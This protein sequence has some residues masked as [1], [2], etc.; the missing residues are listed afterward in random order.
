[1]FDYEC[2]DCCYMDI[3]PTK[4]G[5]FKCDNR[6]SGYDFVYADKDKC[7]YFAECFTWNRPSSDRR[8]LREISRNKRRYIMTAM[9]EI[10]GLPEENPYSV[11]CGEMIY[12]Y[13]I[14]NQD[15]YDEFITKYDTYGPVLADLLRRDP[16]RKNVCE[17]ILYLLGDYVCLVN[18]GN[19]PEA[20]TIYS[21]MFDKLMEHY[22]DKIVLEENQE[23]VFGL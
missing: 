21:Q 16:E 3:N 5:K 12:E 6:K 7:D 9:S 11:S 1:M 18:H 13:I 22:Q 15:V 17:Y 19:F 2:S 20:I 10:L 23:K 8:T 4:D 14:P